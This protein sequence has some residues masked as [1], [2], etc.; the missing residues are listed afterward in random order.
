M[1]FLTTLWAGLVNAEHA[2]ER[3]LGLTPPPDV[4]GGE[5]A[6]SPRGV[7]L[8]S[9]AP[10]TPRAGSAAHAAAIQAIAANLKRYWPELTGRTTDMPPQA[11]ELAL[12]QSGLE[13]VFGLGWSDKAATGGGDMRGSNNYGAR[14][15]GRNDCGAAAWRCVP[16][17]D[18]TPSA[19]GTSKPIAASFRY[20]Q[21]GE[22][23][24]AAENGAY[25][26]LRDLTHT[27]NVV[28]QLDSGSV[29]AYARRLGPDK[30]NGGL[31]Y[32][33]GFGKTF[34]EREAG[35]VAAIRSYLPE[36]AAALGHDRV[37]AT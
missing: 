22:G 5:A 28:P 23:R 13:S 4:D 16:Y 32:Y 18:T 3:A 30:A 14:Q 36:V 35:Y 9:G 21:D 15:C 8:A 31:Y 29:V 20:Y 27:W 34:A 12:A 6:A 24:T 19:D 2:L 33:G 26:F 7:V 25:Y 1:T 37:Y 11:L 17:G 10:L